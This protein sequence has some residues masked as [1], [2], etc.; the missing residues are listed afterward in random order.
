MTA[1][2]LFSREIATQGYTQDECMFPKV[3]PHTSLT[4]VSFVT[5]ENFL[6]LL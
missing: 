2:E 5:K 3:Q 6:N 1:Y 4:Q